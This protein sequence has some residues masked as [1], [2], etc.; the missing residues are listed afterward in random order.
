VR[1]DANGADLYLGLSDLHALRLMDSLLGRLALI[2]LGAVGVAWVISF[3]SARRLLRRVESMTAVAAAIRSDDLS[4]RIPGGEATDEIGYLARTLNGMLDRV[5]GSVSQLRSL[6]DAVAHE[7]KTPVTSIRGRLE[8]TLAQR[9]PE[10]WRET[11][12]LAIEDLDRLAAF[13][14]TTLDLSEAEGGGL[15]LHR[16]PVDFGGLVRDLLALYEPALVERQQGLRHA[17]ADGIVLPMDQSLMQRAVANLLDNELRHLPPGTCVTVTLG[18]SAR[19]V[20]LRIEDNGPGFPPGL[21]ARM[22]QRFVKGGTTG[23]HGLGLAFARAIVT[24]HGGTVSARN[25]SGGGASV[26]VTLERTAP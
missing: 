15:R 9:D 2:W 25:R 20:T 14:T 16:A 26:A 8:N 11:A 22:F 10:R 4:T 18:A 1:N 23:G 24:A 12:I 19:Q 17:I 13:V 6:T 21:E 7:L 5:A 3:V